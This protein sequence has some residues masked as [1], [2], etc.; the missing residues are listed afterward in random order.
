MLHIFLRHRHDSN[1]WDNGWIDDYTVEYISTYKLV[2]DYCAVAMQNREPVRI[3]RKQYRQFPGMITSECYVKAITRRSEDQY[4]VEFGDSRTL[5]IS[6]NSAP[7]RGYY[8]ADPLPERIDNGRTLLPDGSGATSI[9]TASTNEP[10]AAGEPTTPRE[11]IL[12]LVG[13]YGF[14]EEAVCREYAA[15]EERGEVQRDRNGHGIPALEYARALYR[16]MVRD[17]WADLLN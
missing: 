4:R 10:A 11:L 8:H 5:N 16:D 1:T 13:R 17:G 14:D 6:T 9:P 2:A 3:H 15:C 7:G 12:A